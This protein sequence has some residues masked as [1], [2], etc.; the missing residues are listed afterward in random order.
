MLEPF[1]MG[2]K[3]PFVWR[4]K[5]LNLTYS[6]ALLP[7]LIYEVDI[8][9]MSGPIFGPFFSRS[10]SSAYCFLPSLFL[11]YDPSALLSPPYLCIPPFLSFVS[12][13]YYSRPLVGLL[14]NG[15][16]GSENCR[17]RSFNCS[18]LPQHVSYHVFF[19]CPFSEAC[20]LRTGFYISLPPPF[21]SK[22]HNTHPIWLDS[23]S[24]AS[25]S[26]A[27]QASPLRHTHTQRTQT[28]HKWSTPSLSTGRR[29]SAKH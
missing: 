8:V 21:S 10:N 22:Y 14:S 17:D 26:Q 13:T 3:N 11:T 4:Q 9:Q 7:G 27:S 25:S 6:N 23:V 29:L 20:E 15:G 28:T 12:S 16:C 1:M 2:Q 19:L 18:Y 5:K 24:K